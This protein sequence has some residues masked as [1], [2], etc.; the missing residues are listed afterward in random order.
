MNCPSCGDGVAEGKRFCSS[1]GA[2]VRA[3]SPTISRSSGRAMPAAAPSPARISDSSIERPAR[4]LPGTIIA[5]RYR[6][7][8]QV[9]R[10]GMGEVY[11][12]DDLKLGQRVALKF[13]PES[14]S[15]NATAV[16]R[17]QREVR[18]ARQVSHPNVCRVF[19]LGEADGV[20]FISM[21]FV[22]GEDLG[23]LLQRIGRLPQDKALQVAH[24]LCAGLAEA[25]A[26]GVLHRDLKP[27]NV[28][29]DGRGNV[30]I[31]DFGLAATAEELTGEDARAGTPAYM[32]PEQLAGQR[33]TTQSDLYALGLVLY[34]L[35]S[36]IEAYPGTTI[37]EILAQ[38]QKGAPAKLSSVVKGIAPAIERVIFQCLERDPQNRPRSALVIASALP[39]GDPLSAAVAAGETPSPEMV[40]AAVDEPL[41]SVGRLWL[42]LAA[43]AAVLSTIAWLLPRGTVLGLAPLERPPEAMAEHAR[44]IVL[45]L[46]YVNPPADTA[47]WYASD[48]NYLRYRAAHGQT[49][50]LARQWHSAVPAPMRFIYRQSPE[51]LMER[52]PVGGLD[53][54]LTE[55]PDNVSGMI[56]LITDAAGRLQS[57]IAV[58]SQ[59][60]TEA[61]AS[62]PP[63]WGPLLAAAGL[64]QSALTPATPDWLPPV[65]YDSRAAWDGTL[66]GE[67]VHAVA[68]GYRG[69]PVFFRV[70]WPW[71][72]AEMLPR[73]PLPLAERIPALAYWFIGGVLIILAALFL[74]RR[75]L[76][77][78]RGDRKGAA[79][80]AT[81]MF[82]AY[83]VNWLFSSRHVAAS[84]EIFNYVTAVGGS[85]YMAAY[86]YLGYLAIEPYVR[87][88]WPKMLVSWTR[89]LGGKLTDA[90]VGR[91]LLVGC[92]T[93]LLL[94]TLILLAA[95]LPNWI[96]LP[97]QTPWHP[98]AETVL[99]R[100][101]GG[102]CSRAAIS[103]GLAFTYSLGGVVILLVARFLTR[104]LDLAIVLSLVIFDV[105]AGFSLRLPM[106]V[107]VPVAL[108]MGATYL[109]LLFRFGLL[110]M[111]AA[112]F[113]AVLFGNLGTTFNPSRWYFWGSA[114]ALVILAAMAICGFRAALAGRPAF[115]KPV[116]EE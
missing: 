57:F 48:A 60:E 43:M 11:R 96:N 97:G 42:T 50:E 34:E 44:E 114:L 68:A 86:A 22:D 100:G 37:T 64:E 103:L 31:T 21:E 88:R 84:G 10:G 13:L 74:A 91:D 102:A 101:W 17:M 115:G 69:A 112:Q 27:A 66:G 104:R 56:T 77:L 109:V 89:V 78:G 33:P 2:D 46:G 41:V 53:V 19:D 83:L 23:S 59:I 95:A 75:N 1:C 15:K 111:V 85:L 35:F 40:A 79:R 51:N 63:D 105:M 28:M 7:V 76:R 52:Q 82:V 61:K 70:V 99:L 106:I 94:V 92:L 29:L 49:P 55:P 62:S 4:F 16:E 107:A 32:A 30:R 3:V 24:Q 20:P 39:G 18:L 108:V 71:T 113:T 47:F 98:A 38:R 6:I 90:R 8:A 80:I 9:G 26:F 58:P 65:G 81:V 73:R 36:G 87:R 67:R 5:E 45:K 116:L 110:A 72:Q 14:L 54:T 12:A 93:G 25:H